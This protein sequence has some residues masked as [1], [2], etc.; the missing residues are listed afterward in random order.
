MKS[1]KRSATAIRES[2]ALV[3]ESLPRHLDPEV[4]RLLNTPSPEAAAEAER[5]WRRQSELPISQRSLGWWLEIGLVNIA[6]VVFVVLL[7]L[8]ALS[9]VF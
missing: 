6:A 4:E 8:I 3:R 5:Y 7:A 1:A 9:W 2:I